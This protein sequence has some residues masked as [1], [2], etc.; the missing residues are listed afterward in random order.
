V[1]KV[2]PEGVSG[3]AADELRYF[4]KNSH[5]GIR[6]YENMKYARNTLASAT[7]LCE[8]KI[9][10][11]IKAEKNVIK[12]EFLHGYKT[13]DKQWLED[14]AKTRRYVLELLLQISMMPSGTIT[15]NSCPETTGVDSQLI[16]N[17]NLLHY[18]VQKTLDDDK[19]FRIVSE[20]NPHESV[21]RFIHGDFKPDNLMVTSNL[22]VIAVVDWENAGLGCPENDAASLIAGLLYISVRSTVKINETDWK[23]LNEFF[24][25]I[26]FIE[27]AWLGK[28]KNTKTF[29]ILLSK[30]LFTRL[31][32]YYNEVEQDDRCAYILKKLMIRTWNQ[33]LD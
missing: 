6:E 19:I 18:L 31:C 33:I 2:N 10:E 13:L 20:P 7:S 32:G 17:S 5:N 3:N 29:R 27:K 9:P 16:Y 14:P 8:L 22:S 23:K 11:S 28:N 4:V 30:Y 1:S 15:W 26:S 24:K 12:Q 21:V 25:H